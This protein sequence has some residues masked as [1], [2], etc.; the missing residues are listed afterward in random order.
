MM[1]CSELALQHVS[2]V[3]RS[4]QQYEIQ[5]HLPDIGSQIRNC[6]YLVRDSQEAK[7]QK[8]LLWSD[9]GPLR[10]LE[11]KSLQSLLKSLSQIEVNMLGRVLLEQCELS[12]HP[13]IDKP[14][15]LTSTESGILSI[16]KYRK[17]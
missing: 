7:V 9:F 11:D 10:S 13:F 2:L 15:F 8:I 17:V 16:S 6:Y 4:N 1:F 3:L 12:Q 5:K 14:E